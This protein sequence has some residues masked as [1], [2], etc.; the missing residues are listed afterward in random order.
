MFPERAPT[1]L[2]PCFIRMYDYAGAVE[3]YKTLNDNSSDDDWSHL[4]KTRIIQLQSEGKV[5]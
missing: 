5:N 3:A 2:L 4:A 1:V